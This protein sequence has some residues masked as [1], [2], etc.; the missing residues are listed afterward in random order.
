MKILITGPT[1][2]IGSA[3]T[4]RAL[5]QGHE[6]GG[7]FL[8]GEAPRDDSRTGLHC[9]TGTLDQAPWKEIQ[10]FAPDVCLHTAWITT[11]GVYLESP[12][13]DLFLAWSRVFF[14]RMLEIGTS[15]IIGLGTCIEYQ[16]GKEPLS[17][18]RT[19][20]APISRYA[21]CKNQLR[22]D[23]E[24]MVRGTSA[25][26]CWARIF[27]PYGPGEHPT[28][29]CTQLIQKMR[30]REQVVLKTPD[31]VKDYI[32]IDDLAEALLLLVESRYAGLINLGTGQGWAVK[33]IA[34]LLAE[35]LQAQDLVSSDPNST[36]DP[37]D[38]VLADITRLK[39]LGWRQQVPMPEGLNRL[40]KATSL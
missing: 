3:L 17:E 32:Y 7:L 4:R 10:A 38:C 1:G 40:A 18:E 28:R 26:A 27:Y 11:P 33:K 36:P 5:R 16:V 35:M 29:L 34:A 30:R 2:F 14:K 20:A 21:Q 15:H 22:I 39:S 6:V 31:S 8:P 25:T 12:Q 9:L 37:L 13:N 19:P 23:L 24:E